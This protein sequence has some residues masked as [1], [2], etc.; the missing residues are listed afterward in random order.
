MAWS[1]VREAVLEAIQEPQT[2]EFKIMTTS[3][4]LMAYNRG[5]PEGM[6]IELPDW[7]AKIR[8]ETIKKYKP[9]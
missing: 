2:E 1:E 6:E 4:L 8:E 7:L 3:G 5:C 9:S